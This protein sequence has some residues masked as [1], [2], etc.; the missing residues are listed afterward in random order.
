[1][2]YQAAKNQ[3]VTIVTNE[4]GSAKRLECGVSAALDDR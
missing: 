3:I 1:M 2:T 4:Q